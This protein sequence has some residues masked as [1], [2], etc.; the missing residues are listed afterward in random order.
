MGADLDGQAVP[1]GI[2][3]VFGDRTGQR[4]VLP[5]QHVGQP[6]G[7]AL[8][9]PLLPAVEGAARLRRAAGHDDRPDVGRLEHPERGV[10]EVLGA[11]D[12]FE[13]EAQIRF[14]GAEPAHRVGVGHPRDGLGQLV[15]DQR[16]Q[17]GQDLLGHP[18]D[19]VG[20]DEAHLHVE[21]GELRL[22]VGAEILVAVAAR[23]LVVA[24][25]AGDHEQLLE[26]LRALRQRIEGAGL[27]PSG[28]QEVAR[29]LRG[30]A[31]QRRRLDLDEVVAGQHR[32]GGGIDLRAQ[33]DGVTGTALAAHVE[34][35]V[36]QAG[37]LTGGLVELERQGRAL[38][39]H[40]QRRGIDLDLAGSD[41]RVGVALRADLDHTLD[42]DAELR[43]QPVRL[44]EDAGVA[45]HHLGGAGRIAQVD[46]DHATVVTAPRH[47]PG[48]GDPLPGVGGTQRTG[49][50]TAQHWK[51][52]GD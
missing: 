38:P 5:D 23:D 18:D 30:G 31:G 29:A 51:T 33:P 16:P 48:Q 46:E 50:M 39:Q 19:V 25:H 3:E 44:G 34:V 8:L 32:P 21:L 43:T 36:L 1:L 7:A 14:V 10:G 24:L 37:F 41:L 6:L 12:E 13:P 40:R 28:H 52:P 22:A 11:L 15:A 26:Q 49:G 47:P 17:R 27:Q 35:A 4:A 2:G 45:E 42:G 9:G 20:A